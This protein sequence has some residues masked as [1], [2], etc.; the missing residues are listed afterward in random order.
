MDD[1]LPPPSFQPAP[2][3]IIHDLETLRVLSDPLRMRILSLLD[4][5]PRTVKEIAKILNL[6]ATRLYYHFN[7]LE[8][9][10]LI[11]VVHTR[12]VSGI[13]EKH[14]Q[15]TAREFNVDRRLLSPGADTSAEGWRLVLEQTV[16]ALQR[17]LTALA[18]NGTLQ[19]FVA[20]QHQDGEPA[21][22]L[23][24]S[25]AL[26]RFTPG[27]ARAFLQRLVSLLRDFENQPHDDEAEAQAYTLVVA[28]YPTPHSDE[29]P[30]ENTPVPEK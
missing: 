30:P 18:A 11:R 7:L 8:K 21:V 4:D 27:Q 9:H 14:Y 1:P 12:V 15:V 26:A 10:D 28:F 13:I 6:P 24:L 20:A 29:T 2:V 3:K 25:R 16:A 5:R 23:R 19:S 17:D 22:P